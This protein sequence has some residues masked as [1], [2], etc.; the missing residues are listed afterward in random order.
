MGFENKLVLIT[1]G[2]SG[3]G[4]SCAQLLVEQKAD[5]WLL[6]RR[7]AGLDRA[8]DDLLARQPA[9]PERCGAVAADVSD[10]E[11]LTQ[12]VAKIEKV[13]GVPDLLINSAG[14]TRPGYFHE[15]DLKVFHH[16]MDVNYFGTVHTVK[17]VLPGMLA[18]GS[19]HIVNISSIAG[20]LGVF[21][22]T[23]YGA[24]KYAVRGF[25]D[26]LRAEL[27]PKGIHVSIVFPPDTQ[28]PQLEYEQKFKPPELKYLNGY[29]SVAAPERVAQDIL[30]GI[31]KKH[32]LILP[33]WDTKLIYW[34]NSILGRGVYRLMDWLIA[35]GNSNHAGEQEQEAPQE[36]SGS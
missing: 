21:G 36:K 1:G 10:P 31:A 32:Y 8:L 19:G 14:V 34:L 28:T 18:R 25:S 35:R 13:A 2:S 23:A 4:L 12:A 26:A 22:Y 7:Q 11:E 29:G 33:G 9:H 27:N 30:D 5:V 16:L 17:A 6:A 3:I 20:F 24:S 15:L